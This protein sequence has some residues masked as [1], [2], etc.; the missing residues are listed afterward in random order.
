MKQTP[1]AAKPSYKFGSCGKSGIEK[2]TVKK[3]LKE[4]R[5]REREGVPMA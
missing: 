1:P 3:N 5:R 2:N 4:A